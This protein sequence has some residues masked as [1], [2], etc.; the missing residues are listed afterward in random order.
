ML[1][2]N[3]SGEGGFSF[4]SF[5]CKT[6]F[7]VCIALFKWGFSTTDI[8][9]CASIVVLDCGLVYDVASAAFSWH[10]AGVLPLAVAACVWVV[11]YWCEYVCIVRS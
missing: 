8:L 3:V 1:G 7:V 4:V 9:C 11:F 10:R 6:F 2:P 5:M